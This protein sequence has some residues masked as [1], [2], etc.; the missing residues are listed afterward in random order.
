MLQIQH[1][2]VV[3]LS[4]GAAANENEN[5]A[6]FIVDVFSHAESPRQQIDLNG[7]WAFRRDAGHKGKDR[8][9]HEGKGDFKDT[10]RIP[11]VPQAQGIGEPNA[12]Q[13]SFF[14]E[15]FWVRR[16]FRVPGLRPSQRMWLRIGGIYPAAE[17]YLNG[18]YVGYT[19][20]SRTQQ[21][22]DVT[23]F[24]VPEAD[25][26]IAINVCD[27]PEVRLDG[28]W[29]MEE[30]AKNWTGV[31]RPVCCE[32]T[33]QVSVI[34][35]HIRPDLTER[36]V[37]VQV[38]LSEAPAEPCQLRLAL[39]DDRR[40][41]GQAAA[42]VAAGTSAARIEIKLDDFI[43]WSPEHPKL[44]T[45]DASVGS[46]GSADPRDR[47]F[48]RFGMR[49]VTTKGTKF[50]LNGAPLF[51]RC[52][53]DDQY[54]PET[55]CPPADKNW[56][57]S[58]LKRAREYGMNAVKGCVETI[59]QD[60][61]EAA[62]EAG[63]M[64]IQE[65]PF[66]LSGLRANRYTIDK[67]FRD[68]YAKELDGLVRVSRNHAS[69][70]AYSM[71]SELEFSHQTQESFDFFSRD[72]VRQTRALAPHALVIDCT[73]Y[74]NSE[75]TEKGRRDTDFYASVHPKWMKEVLD[76][77]DMNTDRLHPMILHEYNWWSCYPDP[78]DRGKFAEMQL[79]PFW[80]DTLVKTAGDN[81]QESL[82]PTYRKNSLGLQALCRK[83]GIEYARR[84]PD[85]EGYI[86]WLLI[87]FGQ[88][89]EGL[90]D[91][92]WNPKNVSAEEFRKS[93]GDTVVLLAKEG[94]RCLKMGGK[95]RIPL[96]VSHYGEKAL[97]DCTLRWHTEGGPVSLK[98][99]LHISEAKQG[100]L[101]QVG[102]AEVDLPADQP[103]G[104]FELHVRLDN[105]RTV[106]NMNN[107]SFWA[108]PDA[109][110]K[111][112]N[113]T[114]PANVGKT[115]GDGT[116]LRTG[117]AKS[118][119][120][121]ESVTCV[122]ADSVDD[123]LAG[124]IEAGGRCLLLSTGAVIENTVVYY[125]STSFYRNFRT[126]PWNAGTS[127]NS[128]TVIAPHPSLAAFPHEEMCDLQFLQV[129][130]GILPMEFSPLRKYGVEPVIRAI[131]HYAANRNNAYLLEF[132]VGTGKVLATSLGILP[133]AAEHI[134]AAYL[135]ECLAT[136][137]RGER[138]RP[139]ADVPGTEFLKLFRAR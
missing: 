16:I 25:N 60:Y 39:K 17:V 76:E 136:Y 127:G 85:V 19:R 46:N 41:I 44:Y 106:L 51:L 117:P 24:V 113:A 96:A 75:K 35:A 18:R 62:D 93:N 77:A 107:W 102:Y 116:F 109:R 120:I 11:G 95:V 47:V 48:T 135:L 71:S 3:L 134:E 70:V 64:I 40:T 53:G 69:V 139:A 128:G 12:R 111:W 126:I 125:G 105:A 97:R 92:F 99:E 88:Y 103:A 80:L 36:S 118:A 45:L 32:I 94:N 59:P 112:R 15:P 28:I 130:R 13:K 4:F 100:E 129:I 23:P 66:G 79:K 78:A 26:L 67:R 101:T 57:L 65:M 74:V 81:G 37:G 104:K 34:D 91:D 114:S 8:G 5:P 121:P 38:T 63:I 52:F 1:A 122:V 123:S 115:L 90:L 108:F 98:S 6:A 27:F 89:S 22:V 86:L 14:L 55:L 84:N 83:D 61:L 110:E 50:Y 54:Y 43:P 73:G 137:V 49:E 138:F 20:S 87:D 72:L 58:R 133:K 30:C 42:E 33:D 68:Y 56:Y 2:M 124:Y 10:I 29:E 82:I 131:D 132:K 7:Q 9:W 119:A 21:R 31:Y